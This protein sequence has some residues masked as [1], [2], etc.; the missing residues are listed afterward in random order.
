MSGAVFSISIGL[1]IILFDGW[2]QG[3]GLIVKKGETIQ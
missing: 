2:P 1:F 3:Y